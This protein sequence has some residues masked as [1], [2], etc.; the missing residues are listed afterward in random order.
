MPLGDSITHGMGGTDAGYRGALARLLA[1]IAPG[2]QFVG[3]SISNPGSLP[4]L[5]RRHCGH[6]SYAVVDIDRNLDGL[7]TY[8][9]DT[10]GDRD[11]RGPNGGH[12]LTGISDARDPIYPDVVLLLVGAND[13]NRLADVEQRKLDVLVEKIVDLRPDA[14]LIIGNITPYPA[15][16]D[17][18]ATWNQR[19]DAV[20]TQHADRGEN[21]TGVDLFTGFPSG[22]LDHD[23]LHPNDLGYEWIATQWAA[24]IQAL[25]LPMAENPKD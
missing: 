10:Q 25:Y 9:Y 21:V 14:K 16:A 3:D 11:L 22:G 19:V 24:A 1:P 2:F 23:E 4:L 8:V 6:G 7:D 12:W 18:V 5:Q 20:V 13:I 17:F 15:M